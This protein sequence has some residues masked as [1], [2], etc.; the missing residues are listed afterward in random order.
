[1]S[2]T[3]VVPENGTDFNGQ[4]NNPFMYFIWLYMMRWLNGNGQDLATQMQ[5]NHNSDLIMAGINGN[6]EA[7]RTAADRMGVSFNALQ[8]AVNEVS[9]TVSDSACATQKAIITQGYENQLANE[10]QTNTLSRSVDGVSDVVTKGFCDVSYQTQAQTCALS[11]TIRD[12]GQSNTNAIL[13]KLDAI[14]NQ[15]LLDKI[16][17][18]REKNSQ[19]AVVINN[20]QQ[21]ALFSQM[22]TSATSPINTQLNTL[23]KEITNIQGKLPATI[24]LPYTNA[25][26]VPTSVSYTAWG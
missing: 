22:L 9:H 18:L 19:Q 20:A 4:W 3:F 13:A 17:S 2:E 21:S 7:I 24:T 11:N 10:R 26:A 23:G 14:Q 8:S 16:D 6:T 5:D 12:V 15:A 1:M 25:V